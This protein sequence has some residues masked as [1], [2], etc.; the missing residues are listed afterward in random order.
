MMIVTGS[1][2]SMLGRVVCPPSGGFHGDDAGFF[3][4]LGCGMAGWRFVCT[5]K[6]HL[7]E[8]MFA[9]LMLL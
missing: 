5:E 7:W 3:V 1:S 9:Y 6:G 4:G 2:S 8:S